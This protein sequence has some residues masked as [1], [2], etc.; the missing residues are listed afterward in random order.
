V[1]LLVAHR[2][3]IGTAVAFFAFYGLRE[4]TAATGRAWHG[5][6]ALAAALGLAIYFRT[7]GR[8]GPQAP[9]GGE[10]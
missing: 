4:F 6:L 1:T 5:V 8:E 3:L 10:R 7:I 9:Q 2:I